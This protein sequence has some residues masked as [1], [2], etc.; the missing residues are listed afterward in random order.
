MWD[1]RAYR[2]I[3]ECERWERVL[4]RTEADFRAGR[5]S[6]QQARRIVRD[7]ERKHKEFQRR[8]DALEAENKQRVAL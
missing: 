8:L 4:L 5:I 2:I 3:E 1:L 7:G 6:R